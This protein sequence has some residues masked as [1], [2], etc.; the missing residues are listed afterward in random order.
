[1]TLISSDASKG[2]QRMI[3]VIIC[4]VENLKTNFM[5]L[6][7][8]L[9]SQVICCIQEHWLHNF[10]VQIINDLFPAYEAYVKRTDN[11]NPIPP[12]Y[13]PRGTSG[14]AIM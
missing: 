6:H 11:D 12:A 3:K 2:S 13:K 1:M 5:Y 10:E 7:E 14:V 8:I 9:S 4:N